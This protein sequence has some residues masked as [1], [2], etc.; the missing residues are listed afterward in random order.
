M[1]YGHVFKISK[2]KNLGL[3]ENIYTWQYDL[4]TI[5]YTKRCARYGVEHSKSKDYISMTKMTRPRGK[6]EDAEVTATLPGFVCLFT[7][8]KSPYD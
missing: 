7:T 8:M 1:S 2:V 4:Q 6:V 3:F 5:Y